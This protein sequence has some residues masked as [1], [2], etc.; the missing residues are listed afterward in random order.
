ML[1]IDNVGM[2]V[3]ADEIF[4][5]FLEETAGRIMHLGPGRIAWWRPVSVFMAIEA[6]CRITQ[7]LGVNWCSKAQ[8]QNGNQQYDFC[9]P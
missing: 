3:D 4:V 9:R 2:A 5:G 6:G 7:I 1:K 8:S